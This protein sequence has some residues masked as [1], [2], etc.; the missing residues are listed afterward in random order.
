MESADSKDRHLAGLVPGRLAADLDGDVLPDSVVD[1]AH[2]RVVEEALNWQLIAGHANF[3]EMGATHRGTDQDR[4]YGLAGQMAATGEQFG[5]ASG[6]GNEVAIWREFREKQEPDP[7]HEMS[8]R[9]MAEAQCLFL[10]STG[11]AV[12]NVAVKALA[13]DQGLR[14]QLSQRLERDGQSPGL[15]PFSTDRR[16]WV[17]MNAQTSKV[18]T[19]VAESSNVPEVVT[20]VQP[21]VDFARSDAWRDLQERRGEDFHRWRMQ[22]HGVDGVPRTT[23]WSSDGKTRTLKIGRVKHEEADGLAEDI[24]LIADLAMLELAT[25]MAAFRM[26]WPK[27]SVHLGGPDFSSGEANGFRL[28]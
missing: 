16:D 19:A 23:P 8:M 14:D 7:A 17:S 11:H 15:K 13:L 3:W 5:L 22:S 10:M 18:L 4:A 6:A 9:G 25:A 12:A 26:Q 1:Q 21:V 20:L 2:K 27:T 28:Q 24:A